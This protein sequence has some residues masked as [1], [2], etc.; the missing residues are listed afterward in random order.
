MP[1]SRSRRS[2]GKA[3]VSTASERLRFRDIRSISSFRLTLGFGLLF[4]LGVTLLLGI[5]YLATAHELNARSDRILR[6]EARHF[7]AEHPGRLP[8]AVAEAVTNSTS[9]LNRFALRDAQ[10]RMIAGNLD[11]T[12]IGRDPPLDRPFDIAPAPGEAKSLRMLVV[13]TRF[14][15]TLAI[16][17]DITTLIDL[18]EQLLILYIGSGLMILLLV[19]LGGILLSIAPLR[20][21]RA[22]QAAGREIAAGDLGARMPMLGRGDELDLLAGTVNVML[23]EVAR[24]IGQIKPMICA[25]R[26]PVSTAG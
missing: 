20:R 15:Q 5:I 22:L 2:R 12:L 3:I 23:N 8:A 1:A 24:M 11:A 25:R 26:W 17:R 16:A 21:V 7:A 4:L 6:L 9:Q 13:R 19:L 10:G 14:G 18:R